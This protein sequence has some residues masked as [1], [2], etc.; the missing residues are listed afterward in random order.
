MKTRM[1]KRVLRRVPRIMTR[2]PNADDSDEEEH[3]DNVEEEEHNDYKK[4][5]KKGDEN[6]DPNIF[7]RPIY[8]PS[9]RSYPS[10]IIIRLSL[11]PESSALSQDSVTKFFPPSFSFQLPL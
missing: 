9:N 6:H 2:N 3:V 11:S 10:T 5:D 7:Y 1:T 4:D 8:P